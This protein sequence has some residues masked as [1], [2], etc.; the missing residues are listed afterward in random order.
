MGVS[1]QA[2]LAA[3]CQLIELLVA[4][5][6]GVLTDGVIA[7]NDSGVETKHFSVR[8]GMAYAMW[9]RAGKHAAILSGRRAQ[10]VERRA[11]ELKIKHVLQGYEQKAAPFRTLIDGLRLSPSQVC[12]VGDDLADLPVLRSVGL[13]ACP[14]D[15]TAEVKD[16][17]H[18]ITQAPGGRGAVREVVE[19]I[20]KSQG[21]WTELIGATLAASPV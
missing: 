8:D 21:R 7:L 9:H 20:L 11:A 17:A 18:L 15:A 16:A 3:R 19:V 10:A 5:V 13:A 1:A 4:D 12:F 14:S 6:D 2:D